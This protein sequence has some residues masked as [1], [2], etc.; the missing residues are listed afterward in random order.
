MIKKAIILI[1]LILLC[2]NIVNAVNI[3]YEDQTHLYDLICCNIDNCTILQ[4]V[5]YIDNNTYY[6]FHTVEINNIISCREVNDKVSFDI[7]NLT[8]TFWEKIVMLII[9]IVI[10]FMLFML[11]RLTKKK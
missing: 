2:I 10:P 11:Y 5:Q 4:D 8:F 9:I 3:I 6:Q 7:T 1:A